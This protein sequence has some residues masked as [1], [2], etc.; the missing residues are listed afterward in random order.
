MEDTI[1][2]RTVG[3]VLVFIGILSGIGCASSYMP[4]EHT[5]AEVRRT[6]DHAVAVALARLADSADIATARVAR[7]MLGPSHH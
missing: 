2:M 1:R 3:Q 7:A 6:E 4:K 5:I